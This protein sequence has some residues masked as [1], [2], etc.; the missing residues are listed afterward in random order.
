[1][2]DAGSTGSR[3]HLYTFSHCDPVEPAALPALEDEGFFTTKPG[4]SDYR[5]R[6]KDAAESLRGLMEHAIEGNPKS[7]RGCTPIAVKATP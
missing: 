5:G 3:L 6:P 2:I 1:M 4:L 7:E